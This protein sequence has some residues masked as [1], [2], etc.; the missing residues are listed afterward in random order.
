MLPTHGNRCGNDKGRLENETVV[1]YKMSGGRDEA[2]K[3]KRK[4]FFLFK[5][6]ITFHLKVI[7]FNL[8]I[9]LALKEDVVDVV[10]RSRRRLSMSMF[11][12][13]KHGTST[14]Q[15]PQLP[16]FSLASEAGMCGAHV[17]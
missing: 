10:H 16:P 5:L 6:C 12:Q 1:N 9:E 7:S 3:E 14:S 11:A 4:V 15:E 13:R 8:I 2:E 17:T